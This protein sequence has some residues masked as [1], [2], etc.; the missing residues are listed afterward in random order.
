MVRWGKK[1]R[2]EFRER[3]DKNPLLVVVSG[4]IGS[5]K[6]T[7]AKHVAKHLNSLKLGEVKVRNTDLTRE[8]RKEEIVKKLQEKGISDIYSQEGRKMVYEML[9]EG[10][11]KDLKSKRVAVVSGTY[12]EPERRKEVYDIAKEM[13]ARMVLIECLAKPEV[14]KERLAKSKPEERSGSVV[15]LPLYLKLAENP[16]KAKLTKSPSVITLENLQ[17]FAEHGVIP[18]PF[19]TEFEKKEMPKKTMELLEYV[20]KMLSR[21]KK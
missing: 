2:E 8:E 14:V 12:V 18:I 11:K 15:D 5:G 20:N 13:N 1:F 10:I 17:E 6:D 16:E 7:V 19:V 9:G 3:L 4:A 21:T